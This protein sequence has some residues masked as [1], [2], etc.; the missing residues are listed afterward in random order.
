MGSRLGSQRNHRERIFVQKHAIITILVLRRGQRRKIE[1]PTSI[2]M[3][4][5]LDS[6]S[7]RLNIHWRLVLIVVAFV[8]SRLPTLL[9]APG[10]QDEEWFAPPG[11]TIAQEGIPRVPYSRAT[12][13]NSVFRGADEMLFGQPPLSFYV[14]AI[15]FRC[16]PGTYGTARLASMSA[17]CLAIIL[18]YHIGYGLFQCV[19][20]AFLGT[21]FYSLSRLCFFPAI[22]ARPDMLCG[23]LGLLSL[24]SMIYWQQSNKIRW[25]V[26]A[27]LTVGL[28]G[29]THPFALV[30]A[31]QMLVWA[32]LVQGNWMQRFRRG[33]LFSMCVA[34]TFS[35]W[36]PLIAQ[37]PDLF[38]AQFISN[39]IRVRKSAMNDIRSTGYSCTGAK[40]DIVRCRVWR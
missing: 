32:L 34:V 37:R 26:G 17:A 28:A 22:V 13:S 10:G 20:I 9:L 12:S 36:L 6:N 31:V 35:L 1:A 11:L 7:R 4:K 29:L 39:I 23:T 3:V 24:L 38:R 40:I 16:L 25:L 18:T 21:L 30:F 8:A 19:R 33:V 5:N 27:G 14:Q 15:F 2:T